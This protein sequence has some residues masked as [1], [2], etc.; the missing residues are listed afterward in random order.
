MVTLMR[1]SL[2][3]SGGFAFLFLVCN[4]TFD[5]I[6]E[7]QT[8]CPIGTAAGSATCGPAPSSSTGYA[9]SQEIPA[10]RAVPLGR[11][12]KTWG[13]IA[14]SPTSGSG[15]SVGKLSKKE[16]EIEALARCSEGGE[17]D[18]TI[19]LSYRNQCVAYAFPKSRL[20]K[21]A[22]VSER[23]V[24]IASSKAI[25]LCEKTHE[26]G[27]CSIIYSACSEQIFERF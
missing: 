17:K 24:E 5:G 16:A 13:A 26:R 12:I 4:F 3:K 25:S 18:C 20:G 14:S 23:S 21:S 1:F 11:W 6:A 19:A 8:A 7:A 15:A 22:V 9:S 2:A 27:G 10:P